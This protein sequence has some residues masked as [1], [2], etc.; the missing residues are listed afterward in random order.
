MG[1]TANLTQ[2]LDALVEFDLTIHYQQLPEE[3]LSDY[4][5]SHS[6]VLLPLKQHN[7]KAYDLTIL[8][9]CYRM[10]SESEI[11]A[12][13]WLNIHSGILPEW[14]GASSNSWAL[15]ANAPEFGLSVHELSKDLDDGPILDCIRIQNDFKTCYPE[16]KSFLLSELSNR[17]PD[18]VD[19]YI[20]G[21]SLPLPQ[22]GNSRDI[23]YTKRM[24]LQDGRLTGF[25][26]TT[27]HF[28]N[29]GRLFIN[30]AK[31]DLFIE[32]NGVLI[33][34]LALRIGSEYDS[35]PAGRVLEIKEGEFHVSTLDGS[36]FIVVD[37][38]EDFLMMLRN[39]KFS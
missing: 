30:A 11:R 27:Q 16:I 25:D 9:E 1:N 39:H 31:S 7:P 20:R 35:R 13:R 17:L 18:L 19:A 8:F 12:G 26:F 6:L 37:K 22:T 32:I 4:C 38:P 28:V 15:L 3:A 21:T 33:N 29:L 36:I 2:L 23:R 10:I 14:R 24:R 5:D 34:I